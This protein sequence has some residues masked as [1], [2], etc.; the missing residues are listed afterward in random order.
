MAE[1]TTD[2]EFSLHDSPSHLLHRAQQFAAGQSAGALSAAGVTLRQFS[3]LAAVSAQEGASQSNLVNETGIDRSTLADMVFRMEKA[4]L[5]R[6]TASKE[7]ARAKAVFL[8]AKGRRALANATPAVQEADEQLLTAL[9]K[10]RRASLI[11][12]LA[13][14]SEASERPQTPP[15]APAQPAKKAKS[16]AKPA[17]TD[18]PAKSK[19]K[20]KSKKASK[21]SKKS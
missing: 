15:E 17:K 18:K 13:A 6:R 2:T 11:S 12:I 8:T 20:A 14:L 1:T 4:G 10:S 3:V 16:K 7:D 9:P 5:I 19:K 21:K